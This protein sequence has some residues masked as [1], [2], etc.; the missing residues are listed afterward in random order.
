MGNHNHD[1]AYETDV[2]ESKGFRAGVLAGLLAGLP[3][4]MLMG[5]LAGAA[6]MLLL[7]P[8][9]G[10]RTRA[11]LQ[12][13]SQQLREQAGD[14]VDDVMTQARDKAGQLTHDIREQA[15]DT[16]DDVVAQARDKADQITHRLSRGLPRRRRPHSHHRRAAHSPRRPTRS[17]AL[18]PRCR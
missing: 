10:K 8:Q 16:R 1:Q 2:P 15:M 9:S 5:G 18:R 13:Q 12:R 14:T 17:C 4:G 6:T 7:A 11:K 3:A